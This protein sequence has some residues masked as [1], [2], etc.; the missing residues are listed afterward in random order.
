MTPKRIATAAALAAMLT[1][2]LLAPAGAPAATE[3]RLTLTLDRGLQTSLNRGGATLR[4]VRPALGRGRV[5][6]LPVR[7]GGLEY[8]G[9]G[10]LVTVGGLEFAA[11]GRRAT[12]RDLVLDTAFGTLSGTLNGRRLALASAFGLSS[13]RKGFAIVVGLRRLKLTRGAAGA[14]NASLDRPG[15]LGAGQRLASAVGIGRAVTDPGDRRP[16]LSRRRRP[17]LRQAQ[18]SEGEHEADRKRLGAWARTFAIP[19]T[20][21]EV[22]FDLSSGEP[23]VRRRRRPQTVRVERRAGPSQRRVRPRRGGRQGRHHHRLHASLRGPDDAAGAVPGDRHPQER[24][25]PENSPASARADPD[26][27]VRRPAQRGLRRAERPR[28]SIRRGRAARRSAF[29]LRD[30]PPYALVRPCRGSPSAARCGRPF[31]SSPPTRAPRG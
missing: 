9:E 7:G 5:I 22:S 18:S 11:G 8:S 4:G 28:P 2:G 25:T 12:F 14:I 30:P 31:S 29:G 24:R 27:G 15:L 21:G 19:D 1:L 13:E 26:E 17:V 20:V 10:R 16:H 23:R 6:N 3:G